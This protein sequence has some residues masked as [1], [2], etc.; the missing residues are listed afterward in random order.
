M[1]KPVLTCIIYF[2]VFEQSSVVAEVKIVHYA[3]GG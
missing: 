1:E 3:I 2:S